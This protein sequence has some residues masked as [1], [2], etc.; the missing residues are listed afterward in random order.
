MV[1]FP[2]PDDESVWTGGLLILAKKYGWKTT[3][4]TLTKGEQGQCYINRH[5]K[6][7]PQ[8]R[9]E[10]LTHATNTLG[11]NKLIL[12]KFEDSKIK[13][14]KAKME[15]WVKKII[16]QENPSLVFTYDVSGFTGHPDH[17]Q[18]SVSLLQ[19]VKS[20][21]VKPELFWVSMPKY[22]AKHIVNKQVYS[23]FQFPTHKLNIGLDWYR[24]LSAIRKHM[25]QKLEE[26]KPKLFL[27]LAIFHSEWYYKVD[28]SKQYKSKFIDFEI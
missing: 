26:G 11:V 28:L 7:L 21:K 20:L 25:S 15:T 22:L 17:I 12:G 2:H 4:V 5:G 24:K 6:K 1:I 8:I 9:H 10:E 13:Q 3:V 27:Y 19:I 18:L 23:N 16:T 14:N